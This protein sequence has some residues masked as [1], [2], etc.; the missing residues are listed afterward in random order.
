MYKGIMAYLAVLCMMHMLYTYIYILY[1]SLNVCHLPLVTHN[2]Q[3][4][5]FFKLMYS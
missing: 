5:S 2:L 3:H 1:V 4:L